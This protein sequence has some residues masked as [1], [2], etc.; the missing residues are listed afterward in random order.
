MAF[1]D[2]DGA[3]QFFLAQVLDVFNTQTCGHFPDFR[4]GN[5]AFTNTDWR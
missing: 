3:Y 4:N 1:P 2:L 5:H